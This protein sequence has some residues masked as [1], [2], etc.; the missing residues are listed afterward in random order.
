MIEM[1]QVPKLEHP[2]KA[3][4]RR[5]KRTAATRPVAAAVAVDEAEDDGLNVF[6]VPPSATEA[7]SSK[8]R[9]EITLAPSAKA[10]RQ[11]TA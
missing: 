7:A 6:F 8:R 3:R 10:E 9:D 1:P 2:S 11:D 4:P 5:V